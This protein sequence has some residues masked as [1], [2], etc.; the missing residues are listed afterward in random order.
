[1]NKDLIK[2][3]FEKSLNTYEIQADVQFKIA[4]ILSEKIQFYL[5]NECNS[6]LEIGCGTGFLTRHLLSKVNV[7]QLYL[8]DL[9]D[10]SSYLDQIVGDIVYDTEV[11][12]QDGDAESIGFPTQL[13]AVVSASSIQWF[14]DLPMF[15]NKVKIA[16][17]PNGFFVFNTFGPNNLKEIKSLMGVGLNY[18]PSEIL[19][20]ILEPEFEILEMWEEDH[21]QLFDSPRLVLKHLKE[22]GVTATRNDFRWTKSKLLSFEEKYWQEFSKENKVTLTWQVYYF[23]C[24]NKF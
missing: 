24:K 18:F 11:F 15:F 12:F 14:S 13:Q 22:T 19:I 1:M 3:R 10:L 6:L 17:E 9:V 4:Q 8:N 23:V 16:L 21:V 7:K 2:S 20:R 5:P